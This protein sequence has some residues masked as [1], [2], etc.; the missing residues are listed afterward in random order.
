MEELHKFKGSGIRSRTLKI[1]IKGSMMKTET[2]L[3]TLKH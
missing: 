3:L 1:K 2:L